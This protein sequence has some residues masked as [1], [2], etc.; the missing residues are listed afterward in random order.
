MNEK[1]FIY[2][3]QLALFGRRDIVG[4]GRKDFYVKEI[5]RN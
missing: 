1:N 4:F 3:D 2:S 5:I